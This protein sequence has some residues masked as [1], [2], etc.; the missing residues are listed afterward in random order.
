MLTFLLLCI[1]SEFCG[2]GIIKILRL[3][4]ERRYFL[5]LA[6]LVTLAFWALTLGSAATFQIPVKHVYIPIWLITIG[7][8]IVGLWREC[9]RELFKEWTLLVFVILSTIAVTAVYFWYGHGTYPGSPA[10]DGWSYIAFGQ[11][12]W[13][14]PRC[15][16]GGLAPLYQYAAHLCHTRFIAPS[17][18]GFFSPLSAQTGDT[19]VSAGY[20]F[21]WAF[22]VY[23]CA[24]AFFVLNTHLKK[25]LQCLYV[26]LVVFSGWSLVILMANNFDNVLVLGFLPV[27][28]GIIIFI[29][30]PALSWGILLAILSAGVV[31]IYPEMSLFILSTTGLYLLHRLCKSHS[32]ELFKQWLFLLLLAAFLFLLILAPAF[33]DMRYFFKNQLSSANGLIRPGGDIGRELLNPVSQY[34][35]FWGMGDISRIQV[36]ALLAMQ[37]LTIVLFG[38]LIFGLFRLFRQK[39]WGSLAAFLFLS[40]TLLYIIFFQHYGY[41]AYKIILLS[42]WLVI[43]IVLSGYSAFK[44]RL[45]ILLP[46]YR[47]IIN[48][49]LTICLIVF[50]IATS[51]RFYFFYS[52]VV[53]KNILSFKQVKT[54]RNVIG[55]KPL[56]VSV[57][58]TIANEW[59]MYYLRNIPINLF[60]YRGYAAQG[61]VVPFMKRSYPVA[62][63]G[64]SYILTDC[65]TIMPEGQ[66]TLLWNG[67]RYK[68]WRIDTVDWAF[69]VDIQNPNGME[70]WNGRTGFWLGQ[71]ETVLSVITSKS[72]KVFLSAEF[73]LGPS[74]SKQRG[75]EFTITTDK[76]YRALEKILIPGPC[77]I[78]LPLE[79]GRNQIVLTPINQPDSL[80]QPNGDNRIM[81]IGMRDPK[82]VLPEAIYSTLK[83]R[84]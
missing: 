76:G 58:N 33:N 44:R 31:Y 54:I 70:N 1:I 59:A 36:K 51:F 26:I 41:G 39:E 9:F 13:E 53:E 42:W 47:R 63:S 80:T 57:S 74:L 15:A 79:A 29:Q 40:S 3:R 27:L 2:L 20:L 32:K 34:A 81:L 60:P 4:F 23:A 19:Q 64:I 17:L 5:F 62:L 14:Y 71:K 55:T 75:C 83:E 77:L 7:F 66:T 37:L 65:Q 48:S 49:C 21:S 25:W 10:L 45:V 28:A 35:A 16:E 8:A 22:F 73:S 18:L 67:D 11:Y 12:L 43:Y 6:P 61:H 68:L 38:L 69:L 50:I 72:G 30:S 24:A 56:M 78:P 82:I 52:A 46:L 84:R